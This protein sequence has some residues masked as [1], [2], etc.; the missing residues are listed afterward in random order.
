M[1]ALAIIMNDY[2]RAS[3][4]QLVKALLSNRAES[5]VQMAIFSLCPPLT[6]KQQSQLEP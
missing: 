5:Y 6:S 2:E 1:K 3:L 4:A